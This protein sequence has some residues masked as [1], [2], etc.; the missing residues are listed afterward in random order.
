[1]GVSIPLAAA[2]MGP[3]GAWSAWERRHIDR[4]RRN[5]DAVEMGLDWIEGAADDGSPWIVA[6]DPETEDLHLHLARIGAQYVLL[7]PD[8]SVEQVANRIDSLV[9]RKLVAGGGGHEAKIIRGVKFRSDPV[10][11]ATAVAVLLADWLN[12]SAESRPREPDLR[13]AAMRM[14]LDAAGHGAGR[15]M[16]DTGVPMHSHVHERASVSGSD[17]GH[18][19][20]VRV[21]VLSAV[22]LDLLSPGTAEASGADPLPEMI[23]TFAEPYG[24]VDL[25]PDF[26]EHAAPERSDP[27]TASPVVADFSDE[28]PEAD[29]KTEVQEAPAFTEPDGSTDTVAVNHVAAHQVAQ[30]EPAFEAETVV[31]APQPEHGPRPPFPM[32]HDVDF[33]AWGDA[34][35]P[36]PPPAPPA[37]RATP[38]DGTPPAPSGAPPH[39][40]DHF[41]FLPPVPRPDDL[42]EIDMPPAGPPAPQMPW[43]EMSEPPLPPEVLHAPP[44]VHDMENSFDWIA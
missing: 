13:G 28:S 37:H 22:I 29:M 9:D 2:M 5:V 30:T 4:L 25:E 38:P 17:T 11:M 20:F 23:V 31:V 3:V 10:A 33:A 36:F 16:P 24:G 43:A 7:A 8:L 21:A 34:P 14:G 32:P 40:V 27:Y 39:R 35:P 12:G 44:V 41:E 15:R 6:L 1:M 19:A 26:A 18:D 42:A